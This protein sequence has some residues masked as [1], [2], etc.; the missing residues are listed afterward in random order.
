M[1]AG[2]GLSIL[3]ADDPKIPKS[4]S[5]LKEKEQLIRLGDNSKV[6]EVP[7][8]TK[9]PDFVKKR[10]AP[11][12]VGETRESDSVSEDGTLHEPHKTYRILRPA[13]LYP[14]PSRQ[15]VAGKEER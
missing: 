12:I 6:Y 1:L 9:L 11:V 7:V 2:G 5:S 8:D 4:E 15:S 3:T 13:E 10:L 14:N